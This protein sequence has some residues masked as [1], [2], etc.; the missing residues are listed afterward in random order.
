MAS[1]P[2]S[3][4]PLGTEP[5]GAGPAGRGRRMAGLGIVALLAGLG[6]GALTAGLTGSGRNGAATG[7]GNSTTSSTRAPSTTSSSTTTSSTTTS[8]SSTT[9]SSTTS[10]TTPAST[11]STTGVPQPSFASV[12]VPSTAD[13]NTEPTITVSWRAGNATG[14][15]ISIDGSGVYGTYPS[16]G[17]AVVPFTCGPPSHRY[18]FTTQGEGTPAREVRTVLQMPA[19]PTDAGP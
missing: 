15:A 3:S 18:T 9:T 11:T 4:G 17:S 14:V 19:G 12:S 1:I 5:P 13:C 10:T 8:T 16:W 7:P 2:D 6:V